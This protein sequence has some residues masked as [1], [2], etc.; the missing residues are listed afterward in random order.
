MKTTQT[1]KK[2]LEYIFNVVLNED[3]QKIINQI[4]EENLIVPSDI[5]LSS[6]DKKVLRDIHISVRKLIVEKLSFKVIFM[7]SII[8]NYIFT[9]NINLDIPAIKKNLWRDNLI[10]IQDMSL[11]WKMHNDISIDNSWLKMNKDFF[12]EKPVI[13]KLHPGITKRD[14]LDFVNQNWNEIKH[15]LDTYESPSTEIFKNTRKRST[16]AKIRDQ[17]IGENLNS[18]IKKIQSLVSKVNTALIDTEGNIANY[19]KTL[20]KKIKKV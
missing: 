14:L 13:L 12:N 16:A 3:S 11:L 7:E 19:R 5:A 1:E 15:N 6:I 20:K 4:R 10:E 9:N 8:V 17:I 2:T 18:P